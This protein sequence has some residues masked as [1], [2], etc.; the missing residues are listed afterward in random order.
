M[1]RL[2]K[3]GVF[4]L[5]LAISFNSFSQTTEV[6]CNDGKD[7]DGDG[8]I[9]CADS[10]C[11]PAANIEKGCRCYDNV[12]NDADGK[13][14][15]ADP[16]CAPYFGLSFV[17][18]GFNCSITPPGSSTPFSLVGNPTVSGQNTADTQSKTAVG[19]ADGD[20][21]PDAFITSKWNAE[22]RVVATKA[23]T[24]GGSTYAPGD[25]KS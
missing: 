18:N 16:D 5:F 23:H 21:V 3:I 10:N 9:D 22:L 8:V 25:I 12:D 4:G 15:K 17:G 19:D 14:D 2:L 13:I 11:F 7:N 20:G 6:L 1:M 24:V